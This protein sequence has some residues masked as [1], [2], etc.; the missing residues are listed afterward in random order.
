MATS[1]QEIYERVLDGMETSYTTLRERFMASQNGQSD[2]AE[3]LA[4]YEAAL[5]EAE[6]ATGSF[7]GYG[8]YDADGVY[9]VGEPPAAETSVPKPDNLLSFDPATRASVLAEEQRDSGIA[10]INPQ[11]ASV[12]A[13]INSSTAPTLASGGYIYTVSNG[14]L[15][16]L[17]LDGTETSEVGLLQFYAIKDRRESYTK[18]WLEGDTLVVLSHVEQRSTDY[19]S[20]DFAL[21]AYA[22]NLTMATLLDVSDPAAPAFI[23]AMGVT[24]S[25]G[26]AELRD[27][28]LYLVANHATVADTADGAWQ[29]DSADG[30]MLAAKERILSGLALRQG[31]A[32]AYAPGLYIDDNLYPLAADQ[33]YLPAAGSFA[34]ATVFACFDI[35]QRSCLAA[36][37]AYDPADSALPGYI[38]GTNN[39][40]IS[41][42]QTGY[43][44]E[45]DKATFATTLARVPLD[46]GASNGLAAVTEL[47]GGL[48]HPAFVQER[49]GQLIGAVEQVAEDYSRSWKFVA[50]DGALASLGELDDINGS[51][52]LSSFSIVGSQAYVA[53]ADATQSLVVLDISDVSAPKQLK[54]SGFA[55]WP[56]KFAPAAEAGDDGASSGGGVGGGGSASGSGSG[57]LL[58]SYGSEI[59]RQQA[60]RSLIDP[61][62]T[63]PSLE[64]SAYLHIVQV[65]GSGAASDSIPVQVP[66][67]FLLTGNSA[68][69]AYDLHVYQQLS[70]A[71]TPLVG[72][73]EDGSLG[74]NGYA[75]Y[76]YNSTGV[77][78]K[79]TIAFETPDG[80]LSK[81]AL[82]SYDNQYI[83]LVA[84]LVQP[85]ADASGYVYVID[86]QTLELTGT[87]PFM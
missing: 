24:G 40:Y 67:A 45:A 28:K 4:A 18:L 35:E 44:A 36:F 26:A 37:A 77:E 82:P 12:E 6:A 31:D 63:A 3:A 65:D 80:S 60:T 39:L 23:T 73:A 64:G 30:D 2:Y 43:D 33:I 53:T 11:V 22:S 10:A 85:N 17:Q 52:T 57:V 9:Q 83:Y 71:G 20:D 42:Q 8:Y 48:V 54:A 66:E 87:V 72:N 69:F 56:L 62:A 50:W 84:Y 46:G 14:F 55:G 38:W 78:L 74:I 19:G 29:F 13:G 70:V 76:A 25:D 49:D 27:G 34:R 32:I 16:I 59:M 58:V 15:H 47:P 79:G 7:D 21:A 1:E 61:E 68:T 86:R 81:C 41:W 51:G 75:L 5:A